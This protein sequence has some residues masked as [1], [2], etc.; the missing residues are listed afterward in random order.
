MIEEI[1]WDKTEKERN[2]MGNTR[3]WIWTEIKVEHVNQQQK[4]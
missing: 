4:K 3:F 1:T 2:S